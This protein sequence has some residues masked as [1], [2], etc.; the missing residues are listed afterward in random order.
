MMKWPALTLF[1][2]VLLLSAT[3]SPAAE[4]DW[5]KG[6]Y[7]R[8][9][10]GASMF[11]DNNGRIAAENE[12]AIKVEFGN[13]TSFLMGVGIGYQPCRYF[14]FDITARHAP[15]FSLNGDFKNGIADERGNVDLATTT[16]MGTGYFE[17]Q[18]YF[19]TLGKLRPYLGVGAGWAW[20]HL[21]DFSVVE[22]GIEETRVE[23]DRNSR[24]AWQVVAGT[25]YLLTENIVFDLAYSYADLG[26]AESDTR[27]SR[28]EP[29][30]LSDPLEFDVRT[31]NVTIGI[32]YHF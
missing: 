4:A 1:L 5:S 29:V 25:G 8:W 10:I 30:T 28:G 13:D 27:V 16:L 15:K 6:V 32:R 24:F 7:V 12:D 18:P 23:G 3:S 17:L 14:R 21:D 31:H 2:A 11:L 22:A 20:H 19:P 9:D 26:K